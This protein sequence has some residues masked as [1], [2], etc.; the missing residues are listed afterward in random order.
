V[1]DEFSND[2]TDVKTKI[3][4]THRVS[5]LIPNDDEKRVLPMDLIKP[6]SLSKKAKASRKGQ[7]V[8]RILF[9]NSKKEIKTESF[10]SPFT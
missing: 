2:G 8:Q 10:I 9:G 4:K 3:K 6:R 5:K 1:C 7:K